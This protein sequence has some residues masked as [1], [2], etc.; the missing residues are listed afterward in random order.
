MRINSFLGRSPE[1]SPRAAILPAP[2]EN[3]TS[4]PV[5]TVAG[6]QAILQASLALES[7]DPSTRRDAQLV[8]IE[9]RAALPLRGVRNEE[10][11]KILETEI[12]KTWEQELWPLV[13]GGERSISLGAAQA[14]KA[15]YPEAGV[16]IF[17]GQGGLK[18]SQEG[19]SLHRACTYR[20]IAELGL[21]ISVIGARTWSAEEAAFVREQKILWVDAFEAA[22]D[23]FD[24]T[25]WLAS[26]PPQIY[27][28]FDLGVLAPSEAPGTGTAEPGGLF[29]AHASR[30]VETLFRS[31]DVIGADISEIFPIPGSAQTETLAARLACRLLS[32]RFPEESRAP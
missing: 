16:V 8:G 23:S 31:K 1:E 10:A 19:S 22:R 30:L 14:L 12:G 20:R 27:L 29:W 5:G 24:L 15:Q 2:L 25:R 11:L 4:F 7:F 32:A 9:T 21:P 28:A 26:F 17:S 13:L 18:N 3:T 6:P